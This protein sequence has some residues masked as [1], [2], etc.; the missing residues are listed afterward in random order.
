M[1]TTRKAAVGLL[2]LAACAV[3]PAQPAE[4]Q[5]K[6]TRVVALDAEILGGSLS[7]ARV[8]AD[9]TYLGV[10]AGLGGSLLTRMLLSGSHFAHPGWPSYETPDGS[11]DQT[12]VELLHL[13]LFKRWAPSSGQSY[14]VGVRGSLFLHGNSFDDDP[15]FPLFV[16]AYGS[17]LWGWRR[18]KVGPRL[19]VGLFAEAQ[20]ARELGILL[21]PLTGRVE[22]GW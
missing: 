15:A 11:T 1:A 10:T 9:G 18:F 5:R 16:G 4:A 8:G 7:F 12:L 2:L 21:V 3:A 13:G 20:G 19:L 14:D 6:P 17:A 22:F